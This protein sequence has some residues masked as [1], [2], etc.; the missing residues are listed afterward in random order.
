M[1]RVSISSSNSSK[2]RGSTRAE[3]CAAFSVIYALSSLLAAAVDLDMDLDF[4]RRGRFNRFKGPRPGV[5]PGAFRALRIR[6]RVLIIFN[7]KK[8]LFKNRARIGDKPYFYE[9][10]DAE[11]QVSQQDTDS[12]E[13][14]N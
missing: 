4:G 10:S 8:A 2:Q 12:S 1:C 14:N 7:I 9:V 6:I 5:P 11:E 13:E 3:Q